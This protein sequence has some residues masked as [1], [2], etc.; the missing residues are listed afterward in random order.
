MILTH[1]CSFTRTIKFWDFVCCSC[2]AWVLWDSRCVSAASVH[3]VGRHSCGVLQDAPGE[4]LVS[5]GAHYWRDRCRHLTEQLIKDRVF[6]CVL[7]CILMQHI[8]ILFVLR[9]SFMY[10]KTWK[11]D[12]FTQ[13]LTLTDATFFFYFFIRCVERC[14]YTI[15]MY[16]TLLIQHPIF[17]LHENS[18]EKYKTKKKNHL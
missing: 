11:L 16:C 8:I 4:V 5:A 7:L 13:H 2:D 18:L 1:S 10:R 15:K 14:M 17:Y 12:R 9:I 6:L 3:T